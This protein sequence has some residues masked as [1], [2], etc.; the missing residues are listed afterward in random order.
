MAHGLALQCVTPMLTPAKR[1]DSDPP[2]NLDG[3][4]YNFYGRTGNG[5]WPMF[6]EENFPEFSDGDEGSQK[7]EE[8]ERGRRKC[9]IKRDECFGSVRAADGGPPKASDIFKEIAFNK[10]QCGDCGT[11]SWSRVLFLVTIVY[12]SPHGRRLV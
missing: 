3:Y 12:L 9:V 11:S 8:W 4:A 6:D 5:H 2:A 7:K 10:P 1:A